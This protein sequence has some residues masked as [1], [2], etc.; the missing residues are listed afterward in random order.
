MLIEAWTTKRCKL[1]HVGVEGWGEPRDNDM[2][3]GGCH[4]KG[5][6]STNM[7]VVKIDSGG[8]LRWL[9]TGLQAGGGACE[10][11][12]GGWCMGNHRRIRNAKGET[13]G[14]IPPRGDAED[15]GR[16]CFTSEVDCLRG[17]LKSSKLRVGRAEA[18]LSKLGRL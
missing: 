18:S 14:L 1:S 13:G 5:S 10:G 8:L 4:C 15:V 16:G 6:R 3:E 12:R 11:G 17:R 2:K 7:K 9:S